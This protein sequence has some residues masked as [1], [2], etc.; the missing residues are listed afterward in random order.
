MVWA[1]FRFLLFILPLEL[2]SLHFP[3]EEAFQIIFLLLCFRISG[4][5]ILGKQRY[6]QSIFLLVSI[7][8]SG[9][10]SLGTQRSC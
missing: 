4:E 10:A 6:F 1:L 5:A 2:F 9:E 7:R 3:F 8:I